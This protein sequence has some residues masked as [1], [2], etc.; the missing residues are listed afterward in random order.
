MGTIIAVIS[1]ERDEKRLYL[2]P[3]IETIG[4]LY[5]ETAASGTSREFLFNN[6]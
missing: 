2:F 6:I 1:C 3:E 5:R 4:Q